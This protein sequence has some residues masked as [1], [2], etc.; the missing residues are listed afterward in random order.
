M[1]MPYACQALVIEDLRCALPAQLGSV[2]GVAVR[3]QPG[4]LYVDAATVWPRYQEVVKRLEKEIQ[5]AEA[6]ITDLTQELE[7]PETYDNPGLAMSINRELTA[8]QTT[9][10]C[11]TP[12]WELAA[13]KLEKLG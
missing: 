3:T 11:L 2:A 10:D 6:K 1:H 5:T 12:E 8:L 7:K 13:D 9:L 4:Q